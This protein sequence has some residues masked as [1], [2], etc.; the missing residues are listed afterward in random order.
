MDLPKC[1]PR[2][3]EGKYSHHAHGEKYTKIKRESFSL[4]RRKEMSAVAKKLGIR[5]PS[6]TGSIP[7]NKGKQ[8]NEE[9]KNRIKE[10][11]ARSTKIGENHGQWKGGFTSSIDGRK[12]RN[13]DG[14]LFSR[15]E[16]ERILHRNLKSRE[17][18]HH[19]NGNPSDDR[20]ENLF[21][22]RSQSIHI[23]F[24]NY[25]RRNRITGTFLKTNLCLY[26]H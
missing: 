15:L 12:I 26:A 10:G 11:H 24:H 20:I 3:S 22:F 13:K 4:E 9:V 7:W 2:H 18:I 5:P 21:L 16:A 14:K 19:I 8:W 17:I 6:R 25:L 1:C 23:R